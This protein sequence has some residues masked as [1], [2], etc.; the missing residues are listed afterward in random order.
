VEGGQKRP[1]VIDATNPLRQ[2]RASK[3]RSAYG[4]DWAE[5]EGRTPVV[6]SQKS[7]GCDWRLK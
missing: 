1:V 7:G 4:A 3:R 2:G 5:L 6:L